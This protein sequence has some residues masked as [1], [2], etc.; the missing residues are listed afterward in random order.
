[1]GTIA[2]IQLQEAVMLVL[3]CA[4]LHWVWDGV[5][6]LCRGLPSSVHIPIESQTWWQEGTS[7]SAFLV[8]IEALRC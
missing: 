4:Q 1:M 2:Q 5:I 6:P 8:E 3:Q 7:T